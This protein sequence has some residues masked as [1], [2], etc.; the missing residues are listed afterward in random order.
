MAD[1]E[2]DV[3]YQQMGIKGCQLLFKKVFFAAGRA[4]PLCWKMEVQVMLHPFHIV[5]PCP[6]VPCSSRPLSF[7]MFSRCVL[8]TAD[9][10][11]VKLGKVSM[12]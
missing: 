11:L 3:A 10:D 9:V 2:E 1:Y 6:C 7:S 4:T 5:S 8:S 12:G